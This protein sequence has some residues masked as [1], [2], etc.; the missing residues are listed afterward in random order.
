[1][2]YVLGVAAILIVAGAFHFGEGPAL[3]KAAVR[4]FGWD[5]GREVSHRTVGRWLR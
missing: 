3:L 5:V 1:M 4:G 2:K